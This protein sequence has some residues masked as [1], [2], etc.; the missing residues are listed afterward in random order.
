MR[1]RSR[2]YA[3]PFL[4]LGL[5]TACSDSTS[6]ARETGLEGTYSATTFTTTTH[7]GTI[8]RI[9]EGLR[10][11]IT[12]KAGG[13]TIGSVTASGETV[14]VVGTWDTTGT[15]LHFEQETANFLRQ[16][17]FEVQPGKLLGDTLLGVT[18]YHIVLTKE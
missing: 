3:A 4:L 12:L 6:P 2:R 16:V 18:I 14:L 11:S 1:T 15:R 8:D 7:G 10:M 17:P 5:L 13:S 9:A